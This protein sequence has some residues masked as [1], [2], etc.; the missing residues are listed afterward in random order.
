MSFH[1][2]YK[3]RFIPRGRLIS[4]HKNLESRGRLNP[5]IKR[6]PPVIHYNPNIENEVLNSIFLKST[7]D[8]LNDKTYHVE[9]LGLDHRSIIP[10][11]TPMFEYTKWTG[12]TY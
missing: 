10:E 2:E 11:R 6:G 7:I 8:L 4:T 9:L 5:E 1:P 3:N 12:R